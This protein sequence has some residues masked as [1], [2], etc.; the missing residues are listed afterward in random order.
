MKKITQFLIFIL[1]ISGCQSKYDFIPTTVFNIVNN[2][3]ENKEKVKVLYYC[4]G[5]FDDQVEQGFYRLAIVVSVKTNDT[6]NVLTFPNPELDNLT[7]NDS[8]LFYNDKPNLEKALLSFDSLTDEMKKTIENIDTNKISWPK[9]S[10]VV[11]CSNLKNVSLNSYT[12]IIGSLTA[13]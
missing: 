1:F 3:L 10:T 9:Y 7:Q 4:C 2:G 12:T 13:K 8:L 11:R 6:L 5:P